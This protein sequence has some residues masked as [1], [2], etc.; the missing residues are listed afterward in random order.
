MTKD[1]FI[2]ACNERMNDPRFRIRVERRRKHWASM[3]SIR[4]I[5]R[6]KRARDAEP[7]LQ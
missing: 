5:R 4:D 6:N 7:K 3:Q 2:R 1:E